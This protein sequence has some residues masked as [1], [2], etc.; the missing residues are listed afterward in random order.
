MSLGEPQATQPLKGAAARS[1]QPVGTDI[2]VANKTPQQ[3]PVAPKGSVH[4]IVSTAAPR[5]GPGNA[6][7]RQTVGTLH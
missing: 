6:T 4:V 1:I 5:T 7:P 3:L 2:A